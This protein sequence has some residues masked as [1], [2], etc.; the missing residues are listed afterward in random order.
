MPTFP[1]NVETF[2]ILAW[3]AQDPKRRLA[4]EQKME[5]RGGKAA[6]KQEPD[7]RRKTH[8]WRLK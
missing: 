2:A 3:L 6:G 8:P 4:F 1:A 5:G 7:S